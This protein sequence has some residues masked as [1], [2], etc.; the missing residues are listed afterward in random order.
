MWCD[1]LLGETMNN[2]LALLKQDH[3]AVKKLLKALRE[4]IKPWPV[5]SVLCPVLL[6]AQGQSGV[7]PKATVTDSSGQRSS[8]WAIRRSMA[9]SES[10]RGG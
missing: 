9:L 6:L 1:Y 8:C 10:V 5:G 7:R 3:E 2:P 4:G